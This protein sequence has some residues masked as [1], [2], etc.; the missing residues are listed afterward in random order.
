[1]EFILIQS[2]G[3][4]LPEVFFCLLVDGATAGRG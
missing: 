1:M 4:L 3:G 2:R